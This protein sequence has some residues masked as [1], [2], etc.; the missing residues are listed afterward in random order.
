MLFKLDERGKTVIPALCQLP[1]HRLLP[2]AIHIAIDW[3]LDLILQHQFWRRGFC[4]ANMTKA[5]QEKMGLIYLH[6]LAEGR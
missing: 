6:R 2:Y 3:H 1:E 4:K 5:E